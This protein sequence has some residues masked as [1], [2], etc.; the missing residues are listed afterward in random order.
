MTLKNQSSIYAPAIIFNMSWQ[1]LLFL[2][3][4]FAAVRESL[5]KKVVSHIPPLVNITYSYITSVL[6]ALVVSL[7]VFKIFPYTNTPLTWL[8][9]GIGVIWSLGVYF[10]LEATKI[11]MTKTQVMSAFSNLVGVLLSLIFLSEWRLFD[12]G[13]YEGRKL[14]LG[15]TAFLLAIFLN[16][17]PQK[18]KSAGNDSWSKWILANIIFLGVGLF[19]V[20]ISVSQLPPIVILANQYIGSLLAMVTLTLIKGVRL[21]ADRR[22]IAL[23]FFTG[24]ITVF[25]LTCIYLALQKQA[26][27]VIVPARTLLRLSMTV[28]V[29]LFVFK[30]YQKISKKE[31]FGLIIGLIGVLALVLN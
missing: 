15:F 9:R 25:A 2:G 30:E 8:A 19:L 1:L 13:N 26:M 18:S 27:A 7:L 10:G 29:G 17:R 6:T 12:P 28:P 23:S 4:L 24:I 3:V 22:Y 16:R 11:N 5:S 31:A 14:I 20:K 21:S